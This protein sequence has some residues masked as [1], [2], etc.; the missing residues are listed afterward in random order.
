M[1]DT[2]LVLAGVGLA[3]T[4]ASAGA[5]ASV[6]SDGASLAARDLRP[7][8]AADGARAAARFTLVSTATARP[9]DV[10]AV[11]HF[12]NRMPPAMASDIRSGSV[13]LAHDGDVKV[14][15]LAGSGTLCLARMEATGTGAVGCST[16][17]DASTRDGRLMHGWDRVD[18]GY[19]FTALV[20][21]GVREVTIVDAAAGTTTLRVSSNVVTRV[22][23]A[24][25]VEYRWTDALGHTWT[26][27]I[28]Q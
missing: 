8:S 25:P 10:A 6:R 27:Q 15:V 26:G 24:P 9:A 1:H 13:A 17:P 12:V 22:L 21:D 4:V 16:D 23:T 28:L 18:T 19:R 2:K 20:P 5:L 14:W 3:L 11:G 7:A